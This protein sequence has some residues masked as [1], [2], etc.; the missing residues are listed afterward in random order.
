MNFANTVEFMTEGINLN[1]HILISCTK[2]NLELNTNWG[3]GTSRF[4]GLKITQMDQSKMSTGIYFGNG[5]DITSTCTD[6]TSYRTDWVVPIDHRGERL[7]YLSWN[8]TAMRR[9][10]TIPRHPALPIAVIMVLAPLECRPGSCRL[11]M[12]ESPWFWALV[13]LAWSRRW[14]ELRL[15]NLMLR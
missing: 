7:G 13:I 1:H 10:W 12:G 8:H 2:S 9:T 4:T 14:C 5:Q 15:P 6:C 11:S 3:S